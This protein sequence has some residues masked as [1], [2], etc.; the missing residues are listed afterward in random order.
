M[1]AA[2]ITS[3]AAST[4]AAAT[5]AVRDARNV[6]SSWSS[7]HIRRPTEL[8]HSVSPFRPRPSR[9]L[10][11]LAQ[12]YDSWM[13]FH[14]LTPEVRPPEQRSGSRHPRIALT[15][16]RSPRELATTVL[17]RAVPGHCRPRFNNVVASSKDP[18]RARRAYPRQH[19][20][21][22][23]RFGQT[24]RSAVLQSEPADEAAHIRTPS[25][26]PAAAT[27]PAIEDLDGRNVS[28]TDVPIGPASSGGGRR[29][30]VEGR[31]APKISSR[32]PRPRASRQSVR[33]VQ[34]ARESIKRPLD[35]RAGLRA[36]LWSGGYAAVPATR[37]RRL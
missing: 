4:R 26:T 6:N 11:A 37:L 31:G 33:M 32:W 24:H 35:S 2:S 5:T 27:E 3:A 14:G 10:P 36:A 7:A 30:G 16:H 21:H 22:A 9:D 20:T 34:V 12:R 13:Q 23:H 19:R 18:T 15:P 17:R 25:E 1:L 29:F 8:G 28:R